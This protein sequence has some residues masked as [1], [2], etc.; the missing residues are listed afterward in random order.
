MRTSQGAEAAVE[1]I[2][3]RGIAAPSSKKPAAL[4]IHGGDRER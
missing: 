3:G 2:L 4:E 1:E